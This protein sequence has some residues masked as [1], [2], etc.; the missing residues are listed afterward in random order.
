IRKLIGE[1]NEICTAKKLK[2]DD[3]T[4]ISDDDSVTNH[5]IN[6]NGHESQEGN[7]NDDEDYFYDGGSDNELFLDTY[8]HGGRWIRDEDD[9]E[10][11]NVS[12]H[13][14]DCDQRHDVNKP[15]GNMGLK[16]FKIFSHYTK[17]IAGKGFNTKEDAL[18]RDKIFFLFLIMVKFSKSSQFGHAQ[19]L[20]STLL[21][22][23]HVC[24]FK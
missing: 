24:T 15:V 8:R 17:S 23:R 12:S 20:N 19:L 2:Y 16:K 5:D 6:T 11:Y 10:N 22:G 18:L 4:S 14:S 3:H 13:G 7:S 9:Q 21:N 1:C